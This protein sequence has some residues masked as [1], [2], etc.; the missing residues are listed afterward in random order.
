MTKGNL[1]IFMIIQCLGL[2]AWSSDLSYLLCIKPGDNQSPPSFI[3]LKETGR[4]SY[5]F[6]F[7]MDGHHKIDWEL[8]SDN[9]EKN[10]PEILRFYR[11]SFGFLNWESIDLRFYKYY[12]VASFTFSFKTTNIQL[13]SSN[14]RQDIVFHDCEYQIKKLM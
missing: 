8:D 5:S 9:I 11:K 4:D 2:S 1:L 7:E 12:E 13:R 3:E 14:E 6:K 10:E